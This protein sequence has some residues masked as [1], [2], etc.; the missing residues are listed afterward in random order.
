[1]VLAKPSSEKV[2]NGLKNEDKA[3]HGPMRKHAKSS[4]LLTFLSPLLLHQ[5]H[6]VG[7]VDRHKLLASA[8]NAPYQQKRKVFVPRFAKH[9]VSLMKPSTRHSS[10]SGAAD[11][12]TGVTNPMMAVLQVPGSEEAVRAFNMKFPKV[13]AS[14]NPSYLGTPCGER[15][16]R[17][18]FQL[19]GSLVGRDNAI[20]IAT[21]EPLLLAMQDQN[22]EASWEALVYVAKGDRNAALQVVRRHPNCLIAPASDIRQKSLQEFEEVAKVIEGT[23]PFMDSLRSIGPEGLAVGAAAVGIAA[24]GALANKVANRKEAPPINKQQMQEPGQT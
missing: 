17:R 18:R 12:D 11:T 19:L 3:L 20:P 4:W 5:R 15:E 16:L 14:S 9:Q 22:L 23:E 24:I 10:F 7:E 1:M 13:A 8:S 6:N 21:K 2:Y